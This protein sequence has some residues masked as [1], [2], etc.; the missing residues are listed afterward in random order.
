MFKKKNNEVE[1]NEVEN[2]VQ[3][4][5][6]KAPKKKHRVLKVIGGVLLVCIL[7][8]IPISAI[9][10][11]GKPSTDS[12]DHMKEYEV[13]SGPAT[14][15]TDSDVVEVKKQ[16][17][18]TTELAPEEGSK[19]E[20][21]TEGSNEV[22]GHAVEDPAD[23]DA[24]RE[25][26][27]EWIDEGTS[28]EGSAFS[29]Y[30]SSLPIAM[31]QIDMLDNYGTSDFYYYIENRT[32]NYIKQAIFFLYFWDADGMPVMVSPGNDAVGGDQYVEVVVQNNLAPN[33][34]V[35]KE[36]GSWINY[37]DIY[38]IGAIPVAY[39][40]MEGQ[41]WNNAYLTNFMEKSGSYVWEF[42]DVAQTAVF[43]F[44]R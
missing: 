42:R 44:F 37:D 19:L 27:N 24:V 10:D 12:D 34:A 17:E 22:F 18:N 7:F 38:Y 28:T 4:E 23:T 13:V 9:N 2:K 40:T 29:A 8:N 39:E 33:E 35:I 26:A 3:T 1:T 14:N 41:I 6:E 25:A 31:N 36:D 30:D 21:S 20:E 43:D 16:E 32:S 15:T 11:I 5:Q